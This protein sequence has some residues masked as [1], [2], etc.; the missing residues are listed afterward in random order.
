MHLPDIVLL[1]LQFDFLIQTLYQIL[2]GQTLSKIRETYYIWVAIFEGIL[3][4]SNS[5]FTRYRVCQG[6][7]LKKSVG[8]I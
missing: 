1:N 7:S 4:W 5:F 8:T 3:K 2:K 6:T